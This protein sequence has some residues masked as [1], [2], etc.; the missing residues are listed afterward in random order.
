MTT[1]YT[2]ITA[3]AFLASLSNPSIVWEAVAVGVMV[4]SGSPSTAPHSTQGDS[5]AGCGELWKMHIRHRAA[6]H[7]SGICFQNLSESYFVVV[8]SLLY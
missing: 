5:A 2:S 3:A 4:S 7:A 1:T 8:H 6:L